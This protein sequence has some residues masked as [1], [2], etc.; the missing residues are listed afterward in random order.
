MSDSK[1]TE[2]IKQMETQVLMGHYDPEQ[3]PVIATNAMQMA[4]KHSEYHTTDKNKSEQ[5]YFI[6][7]LTLQRLEQEAAQLRLDI[8]TLNAELDQIR[9]EQVEIADWL[10]DIDD[11]IGESNEYDRDTA[12]DLI[13]QI[14]G[15]RPDDSMIDADIQALLKHEEAQLRARYN[16]LEDRANDVEG[17]IADKENRLGE[18]EQ[19]TKNL[20]DALND[21]STSIEALEQR[22]THAEQSLLAVADTSS[23]DTLEKENSLSQKLDNVEQEQ[24]ASLKAL[25]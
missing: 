25:M 20:K 14:T 5:A 9:E 6:A 7:L 16:D 11:L 4:A 1:V 18:I 10:N 2:F 22:T 15:K 8:V 19:H 13:E 24:Q 3:L 21:P 12:M 23:A 17:K